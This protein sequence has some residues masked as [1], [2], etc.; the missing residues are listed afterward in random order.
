VV[1]RL[2]IASRRLQ[3]LVQFSAVELQLAVRTRPP[4]EDERP[5]DPARRFFGMMILNVHSRGC[6]QLAY[7]A[8]IADGLA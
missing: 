5:V 3:A 8:A 2:A 4:R 6:R 7:S 1:R